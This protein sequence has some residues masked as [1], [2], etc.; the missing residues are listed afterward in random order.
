ME[1]ELWHS[2]EGGGAM[3]SFHRGLALGGPQE[4]RGY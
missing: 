1:A 2:G 4:E 3:V